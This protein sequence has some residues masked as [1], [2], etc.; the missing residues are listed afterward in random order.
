MADLVSV[1]GG[2]D[3]EIQLDLATVSREINADEITYEPEVFAGL[4]FKL[5]E[6]GPTTMVFSNGKFNITGAC[7]IEQLHDIHDNVVSELETIVQSRIPEHQLHVRNLVYREEYGNELALPQLS[8]ELG[9]ELTEFMPE[10]NASLI[11]S[12]NDTDNGVLLIF[13]SGVI[14]A[15]GFKEEQK[16]K[17]AI[18]K[19]VG[20]LDSLFHENK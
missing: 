5:S 13:A 1:V 17:A 6:S 2:G 15:T 18:D 4:Y 7:N 20:K 3:F 8:I 16:A 10:S 12:P 11:Y 14:I 19:I 9:S